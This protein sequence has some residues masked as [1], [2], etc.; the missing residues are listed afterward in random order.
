MI[1]SR[2]TGFIQAAGLV[3]GSCLLSACQP[4]AQLSSKAQFSAPDRIVQARAVDRSQ[5][6]PVVQLSGD[7]TIPMVKT[8][9]DTWSGTINVLP[10]SNYFIF[11]DWIETLPEGD[12]LL[13]SWSGNI[14]VDAD[15]TQLNLS[16]ANYDY[17]ADN[18]G[19]F[20]SNIEERENNT[21]PF[22]FNA[23][24]DNNADAGE[25][26]GNNSDTTGSGTGTTTGSTSDGDTTSESTGTTA[27]GT[28]DQSTSDGESTSESTGTVTGDT[29]SQGTTDGDTTTDGTGTVT[30]TT[31]SQ[32]TSD[33]DTT[34][35][36][37]VTEGTAAGTTTSQGTSDGDTTT[38]GTATGATTSEGTSTDGSSTSAGA[39]D[40]GVTDVGT[41]TE[42]SS[43]STDGDE[44]AG[45]TAGTTDDGTTDDGDT[46]GGTNGTTQTRASVLIPSIL[47]SEAPEIDGLGVSVNNQ[48]ELTGEWLKAV[49]VDTAGIGLWIDRLMIDNISGP[50]DNGVDGEKY[51][52][53][54]A[55]HDGVNLYVVVMSDD[56]GKRYSDSDQIWYDDSLELFIDG[57]HSKLS[58]WGDADD[59][60]YLIALQEKNSIVATTEFS[61][62]VVSRSFATSGPLNLS[63]S[64]GPGKGP[65]GIRIAKW[66]Q[67]VYE[68]SIPIAGAGITIGKTFGFELQINDDDDE[69]ARD[70]KW[71]WAHPSRMN[72]INADESYLNPSVMGTAALQK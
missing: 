60:H 69:D 22:T 20:I 61:D 49:Q 53:W 29:T 45:V 47:P 48:Q 40:T 8:G 33:G 42:G 23:S 26:D 3:L 2:N 9:D 67:D 46:T 52:R 62:R 59:Y 18:D 71:G 70:T 27:G 38:E 24:P 16:G 57:N 35:E 4:E 31:T 12:L 13:A 51:R 63:V 37:T 41:T 10:N 36:G 15:G 21:D 1:M 11:V 14:P 39:S 68:L 50:V 32:G 28:T 30:G 64:T 66:E 56:V 5:L 65:R 58:V 34:T 7:R 72:D 54:A 17:T 55:M 6:R 44:T 19:D 25:T 43:T